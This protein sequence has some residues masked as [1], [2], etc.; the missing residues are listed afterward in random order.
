MRAN[1]AI[2]ES[3]KHRIGKGME[4]DVG[5]GMSRER[6]VVW[7]AYAPEGDVIARAARVDVQSRTDANI[8]EHGKLLAF[9]PQEVLR[10]RKLDVAGLTLEHADL[11][12]GPFGQ[13][14]VVGKIL[15][16]LRCR[17]TMCIKQ[18]RK[19]K[20]LRRLH[21]PDRVA[22]ESCF[23]GASCIDALDGVRHR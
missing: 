8:A 15:A 14:S 11:H 3:T 5:V 2:R 9:G 1:V 6:L 7:N 13:G 18:C 20:C 16:A 10:R 17:A 19:A 21:E 12:A 4:C 22:I 23:N